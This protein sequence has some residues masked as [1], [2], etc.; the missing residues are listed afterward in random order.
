MTTIEL[1]AECHKA[2]G[3]PIADKPTIAARGSLRLCLLQEELNEL[4]HAIVNADLIGVL[5]ALSDLQ[6]VLDGTYLEYGFA[7]IKTAAFAEVHRS[8]MS[9]LDS[10]G[11]P[12]LRADGKFLK[13]PFYTPPNLKQFIP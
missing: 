6:Y 11:R 9:K 1:V 2:F 8:N 3:L 7:D 12:L 4:Q 10:S 5:D 13:G